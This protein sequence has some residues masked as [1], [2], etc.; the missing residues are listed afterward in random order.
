[1]SFCLLFPDSALAC[2]APRPVFDGSAG[3]LTPC[4]DNIAALQGEAR[5]HKLMAIL[6]ERQSEFGDGG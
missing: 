3:A 5:S 1:M 6:L 2:R 4:S